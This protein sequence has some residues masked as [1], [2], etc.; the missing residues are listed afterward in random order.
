MPKTDI[1]HYGISAVKVRRIVCCYY[2]WRT[3]WRTESFSNLI[4][5][6]EK[7]HDNTVPAFTLQDADKT[8]VEG[9]HVAVRMPLGLCCGFVQCLGTGNIL[10]ALR[11]DI[12]YELRR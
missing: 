9:E 10:K 11:A 6:F 1:I 8:S 4:H 3:K 5:D 7:L 12:I 2:Q